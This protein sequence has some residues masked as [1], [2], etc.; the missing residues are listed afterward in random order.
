MQQLLSA[1][2]KS[3]TGT[4]FFD[5]N[6][7]YTRFT[8]AYSISLHRLSFHN[9]VSGNAVFVVVQI[10][11]LVWVWERSLDIVR[12]ITFKV[13]VTGVSGSKTTR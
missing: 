5:L 12:D 2:A 10:E 8:T 6:A 7:L 4:I 11:S 13:T 9:F 3:I 1:A